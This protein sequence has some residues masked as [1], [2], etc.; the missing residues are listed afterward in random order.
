MKKAVVALLLALVVCLTLAGCRKDK[1]I[2]LQDGQTLEIVDNTLGEGKEHNLRFTRSY[3]NSTVT[4][5]KGYVYILPVSENNPTV[6]Y[7][8]SLKQS[9]GSS[10]TLFIEITNVRNGEKFTGENHMS[11]FA[12]LWGQGLIFAGGT[13]STAEHYSSV[14]TTTKYCYNATNNNN[15]KVWGDKH[16]AVTITSSVV[17]AGPISFTVDIESFFQF[18]M[19]LTHEGD[20][21][22]VV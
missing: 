4:E 18:P 9:S 14:V 2:W 20:S 3:S 13:A 17:S 6:R 16:L 10:D 15:I 7:F 1:A 5:E 19:I 12:E 21:W 11:D 22:K 8:T